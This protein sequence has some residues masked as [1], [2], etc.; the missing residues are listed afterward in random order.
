MIHWEQQIHVLWFPPT[1]QKHASRHEV[2]VKV[3][4]Y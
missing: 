1:D 2:G 3:Y 4:V